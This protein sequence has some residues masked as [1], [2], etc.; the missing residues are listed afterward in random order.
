MN[1]SSVAW[2]GFGVS[3]AV[4][5]SIGR[6]TSYHAGR[7][8]PVCSAGKARSCWTGLGLH[9]LR[10]GY[11]QDRMAEL[12]RLGLSSKHRLLIVSQELGHFR[13]EI[14]TAYLR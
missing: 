3:K 9:G 6:N 5:L 12:T 10:H 7:T 1:R 13:P 8:Y 14:V 11:A 4:G 2:A